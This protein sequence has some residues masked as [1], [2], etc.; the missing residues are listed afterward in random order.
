MTTALLVNKNNDFN[1][2][3]TD[4]IT[5]QYSNWEMITVDKYEDAMEK[6]QTESIDI[7]ALDSHLSS[8]D[9]QALADSLHAKR[10]EANIYI[11]IKNPQIR[12]DYSRAINRGMII[13]PN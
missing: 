12:T 9:C 11:T 3:L 13:V 10:P 1:Q 7:M 2:K 4:I 6:I 5:Q 8:K